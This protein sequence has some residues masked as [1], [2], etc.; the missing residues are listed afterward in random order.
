MECRSE[1]EHTAAC[2]RSTVR[3][4]EPYRVGS[5]CHRL[6]EGRRC[7]QEAWQARRQIL[8]VVDDVV[9]DLALHR[10]SKQRCHVTI[11]IRRPDAL[12]ETLRVQCDRRYR[13]ERQPRDSLSVQ[14]DVVEALAIPAD[15]W[16]TRFQFVKPAEVFRDP[17]TQP[18][19]LQSLSQCAVCWRAQILAIPDSIRAG[20]KIQERCQLLVS[21]SG[22]SPA[23]AKHV[24]G[25]ESDDAQDP[26]RRLGCG[27]EEE[28]H[29]PEKAAQRHKAG[30]YPSGAVNCD[31]LVN[32]GQTWHSTTSRG[33]FQRIGK[34]SLTPRLTTSRV[35]PQ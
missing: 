26:Q 12:V 17:P 28:R 5:Q 9:H 20:L 27:A 21:A 1:R 6:R 18:N 14:T 11:A 34:R 29:T 33:H 15:G 35:D 22:Q 2:R 13:C 10:H 32:P 3:G 23:V 8:S 19:P 30:A 7:G 24:N 31:A 16:T 4:I 25:V